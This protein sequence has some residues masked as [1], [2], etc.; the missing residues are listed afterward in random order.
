MG[1][2]SH[3]YDRLSVDGQLNAIGFNASNIWHTQTV[4][5]IDKGVQL[6]MLLTWRDRL[7]GVAGQRGA[8]RS[9]EQNLD[10][11]I[12]SR[13]KDWTPIRAACKRLQEIAD[14]IA[15]EPTG[16]DPADGFICAAEWGGETSDS[17]DEVYEAMSRIAAITFIANGE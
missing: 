8:I 14:E 10:V 11:F 13:E 15:G 12:Y 9:Y 3:I 7:P 16:S 6:F 2:S 17:Y 4:D 1:L 5:S